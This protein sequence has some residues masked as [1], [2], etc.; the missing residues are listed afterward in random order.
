MKYPRLIF[1]LSLA[2]VN[3]ACSREEAVFHDRFFAFGT[4]IEITL[5]G[6]EQERAIRAS[7]IIE[8][9]FH[10]RHTDWHAW[11]PGILNTTNAQLATLEPFTADP[12]ILPLLVEA[13]RLS[14]LSQGL[15]NPTIG[16][17]IALWGFQA[18]ELPLGTLPD[19]GAIKTL[20]EQAPSVR[21]VTITGERIQNSNPA[22]QYD[23]GA[24]AK[25]YAIDRSIDRLRELGI[26]NAIINTGGDLRGIGRHGDRPWR[27]GIRHPRESGVLASVE[28]DGDDSVFTSGDY[29]RYF[30]VDGKRYH[31]IID[32]RSGF[33]A[34]TT[35]SV[36]V[37]HSD[38][39]TADAAATAL[40]VAG[41]GEW[42]DIARRMGVHYV[43]LVDTSG[44][45]HMN[46]A[47]QERIR[48]EPGMSADIRVSEPL[49]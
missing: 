34:D 5:Y 28:L 32:P 25:G 13:G 21:D 26:E 4:L 12:A 39:A 1:L 44:V 17:L 16:K 31:H 46:P 14:R 18:D 15:F 49:K 27:I 24:F 23:L 40:F 20:V 7:D 10:Q 11:E 9:E 6:V 48:F 2:C 43:M 33:P 22:V 8:R 35:T 47:M 41:P 42:L 37:I 3:L 29:E 30:E 38:A 45:I 36:T 19:P